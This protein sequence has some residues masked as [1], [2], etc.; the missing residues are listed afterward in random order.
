MSNAT[1][2]SQACIAFRGTNAK[3]EIE[4]G[5]VHADSNRAALQQLH[6]RGITDVCLYG[7]TEQAKGRGDLTALTDKERA[8]LAAFEVESM[9]D[10]SWRMFMREALYAHRAPLIAGALVFSGAL[11]AGSLAGTISGGFIALTLPI[12]S[13]WAFRA[14]AHYDKGVRAW[15]VG[16]WEP[17]ARHFNWLLA[18]YGTE[19]MP[20]MVVDLTGRMAVMPNL[21]PNVENA[22]ALIEARRELFEHH[23]P[24]AFHQARAAVFMTSGDRDRFL[25]ECRALAPLAESSSVSAL[26]LA[27]TEARFGELERAQSLLESIDCAVLPQPCKPGLDWLRGEIAL[28]EGEDAMAV[29]WLNAAVDGFLVFRNN[30]VIWIVLA[31]STASLALAMSRIGESTKGEALLGNV[32][33]IL[34]VHGD[35][36]QLAKLK[37]KYPGLLA[38][39]VFE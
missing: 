9:T 2:R 36:V 32:L 10:P 18:R 15:A 14:S 25:S 11:Y 28:R 6:E 34:L 22:L 8:R 20:E 38:D 37:L 4:S 30:P 17:A 24:G 13:L 21:Y 26:D 5:F 29:R 16:D 23:L 31:A 1:S 39:T 12:V 33:P 27:L 19:K 7:D 35:R 3:G